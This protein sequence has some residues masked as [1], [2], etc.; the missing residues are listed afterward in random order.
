MH[1]DVGIYTGRFMRCMEIVKILEP[2]TVF[3]TI[4]DYYIGYERDTELADT[5]KSFYKVR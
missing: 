4:S 3:M 1:H 5:L 2:S